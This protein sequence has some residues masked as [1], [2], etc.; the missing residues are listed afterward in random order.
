MLPFRPPSRHPYLSTG[1]AGLRRLS[2][3]TREKF[4]ARMSTRPPGWA[5]IQPSDPHRV[6]TDPVALEP[7][8]MPRTLIRWGFLTLVAGLF[9][10]APNP[11]LAQGDEPPTLPREFRAAWVA[12]VNNID[13]PS[14]PGLDADAQRTEARAILDLAQQTG[15]NAVVFQVRTAADALYDSPIEPWSAYLTGQQGESPGYDPLAFWVA[16]AHARGLALHAW[17]NP[18][19]ARIGGAKYAESAGH[20]SQTHPGLVRKY[21]TSLWLDPGEPESRALT[22]QVVAD[23]ARRYDVDGVHVDDYFYPY[24]IPD[25]AHPGQELA[26]PDDASWAKAQTEGV[27]GDRGDWRRANI[28]ATLQAMARAVHDA[29]PQT[30]FGISPFGI[31][32]PGVPPEV[33]GFDQYAQLAADAGLWFREGYCDYLA[34]QLYWPV[35]A[36]GQ[37]FGP[38]L[39]SWADLNLK[40]RHLWPGLSI[41]RVGD[42]PKSFGPDEIRRQIDLLRA[43][44]TA[45]GHILFSFKALQRNRR[46]IA[47]ELRGMTYAAP[48]L[49]PPTP[50]LGGQ[51]P[52]PPRG[53]AGRRDPGRVR[54]TITPDESPPFVWA[55][56]RQV[57]ERWLFSVHP[58]RDQELTFDD[59][60]T[61]A[62]ASVDRLGNA[63]P[64]VTATIPPSPNPEGR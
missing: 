5:I 16:E 17:I 46:G 56:H 14:R 29:K 6:A 7:S 35:D 42:G 61:V 21:G 44:G 45:T 4:P 53:V 12:T 43:S 3:G 57:G 31:V 47:D 11:G 49:I 33:K 30:L 37:P 32:R 41:S 51:P 2:C 10:F 15:L 19:R 23:I 18:F 48:A 22:L 34:P 1:G 26:F 27:T 52:A 50:W 58:A 54:V 20:I 24:P 8:P 38:L 64:P 59:A 40:Q 63:S 62:V 60:R 39:T 9:A 25:P 36:P 13:W 28:N 55:V